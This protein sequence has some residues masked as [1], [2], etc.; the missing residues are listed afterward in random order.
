LASRNGSHFSISKGNQLKS[1]KESDDDR[2]SVASAILEEDICFKCGSSTLNEPSW[3]DLIL[4]DVCDG[5]FHLA[6]AGLDVAPRSGWRC[7]RCT[8]EYLFFRKLK[9]EILPYFK[10]V[11]TSPKL[12]VA[13]TSP[14]LL[15]Q[16]PR[17]SPIHSVCYSPSKPLAVAWTECQAKGF[18]VVQNIFPLELLRLDKSIDKNSLPFSPK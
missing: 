11:F 5:E 1:A 7:Q 4:C 8:Q 14:C 13:M 15:P 10:V 18:M 12:Y 16:A 3:S 6:C 17:Q 9:Y 2:C